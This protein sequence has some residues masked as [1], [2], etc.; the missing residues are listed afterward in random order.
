VVGSATL[1]IEQWRKEERRVRKKRIWLGVVFA[2]A[3]LPV[4]WLFIPCS[5]Y[6]KQY[7]MPSLGRITRIECG[8]TANPPYGRSPTLLR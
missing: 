2:I 8:A 3:A 5:W 4:I 7:T 1:L 6:E